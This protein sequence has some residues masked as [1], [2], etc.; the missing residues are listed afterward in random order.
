MQQNLVEHLVAFI[1]IAE[2]SS[3]SQAARQMGRPVST[4]S[5][6]VTKLEEHCGFALLKRGDGATQLTERGRALLREAK[7]VVDAARVFN[8]RAETLMQGEETHLRLGIDILFPY[9][10]LFRALSKFAKRH[11]RITV[12]L[13]FTSLNRFWEQLQSNALDFGIAPLLSVPSDIGGLPI[14]RIELIPVASRDHPLAKRNE[15]IPL[16]ELRQHRQLYYVE[17]TQFDL[18]R[19]GRIFGTDIWTSNSIEAIRVATKAGLGWVFATRDLVAKE[20][21]TGELVH[22]DCRDIRLQ[23][24]WQMGFV[25][26]VD[27]PPGPL[28]QEL[29]QLFTDGAKNFQVTLQHA[30]LS[31]AVAAHSQYR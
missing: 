12:Q 6:S 14:T 29:L 7:A 1:A 16:S 13:F 17:S 25:W 5:Y 30:Y 2:A 31:A 21:A 26:H 11:P 28:G 23:A 10:Q 8:G 3:F 20:L 4:M 19:R 27:R 15:P 24:S 22:L 9:A 18:E